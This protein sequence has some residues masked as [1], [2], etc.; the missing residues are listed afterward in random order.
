MHEADME[1]KEDTDYAPMEDAASGPSGRVAAKVEDEQ[2]DDDDEDDDD[3]E[4]DEEEL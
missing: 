3:D 1:Y 2:M 4:S